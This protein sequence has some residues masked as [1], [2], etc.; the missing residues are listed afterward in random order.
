MKQNTVKKKYKQ[1]EKIQ[2]KEYI[3]SNFN[4]IFLFFIGFIFFGT[5]LVNVKDSFFFFNLFGGLLIIPVIYFLPNYNLLL[6]RLTSLTYGLLL[7]FSSVY[8]LVILTT[9][10]INNL[11]LSF[12]WLN[13]EILWNIASFIESFNLTLTPLSLLFIILTNFL[14]VIC[15]LITWNWLPF[16]YSLRLFIVLLFLLQFFCVNF[17]VSTH[18]VVFYIFFESVLIPMY[19]LIGIWGLRDR[20]IHASYQFFLYTFFG[21]LFMLL[22]LIVLGAIVD[23]YDINFINRYWWMITNTDHLGPLF[24]IWLCFF[25]GFAIKIPMIPFH[26]WLPEAH[27]EAPTAGSIVLAGILLKFGTYGFYRVLIAMLP[28]VTDYCF[29][30]VLCLSLMGILYASVINYS[31]IDLKKIIAYSSVSHMGYVTLG[32]VL[33]NLEGVAGAILMMI[34]HGLISGALFYIVGILYERYGTRNIY[35][36]G[37]LKSIMPKYV[38]FFFFLTLANMNLPLTAG[39]VPEFLVLLSTGGLESKLISFLAAF[40]LV[41]N[42]IYCIWLFNRLCM[43][44][45]INSIN[46]IEYKDLDNREVV[47]LMLFALNIFLLG[48]FPNSLLSIIE[49]NAYEILW[50]KNLYYY[51]L[52]M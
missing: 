48:I 4:S 43:G 7:L 38:F 25:L 10:N 18:L 9:S 8:L 16:F 44:V 17:F 27:V 33:D 30:F 24:F 15:L 31:Q 21:S 6:L 52:H 14:I 40:G 51:N 3:T 28:I 49:E 32:L 23:T 36:Y 22:G 47:I 34:T 29:K 35:Y 12:K 19:F 11:V 41:T 5:L 39:F 2:Y 42:G 46:V 37:G 20:K 13:Y 1:I 45:N 50:G 26:I